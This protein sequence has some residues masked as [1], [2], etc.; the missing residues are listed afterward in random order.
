MESGS[1]EVELYQ[2][3]ENIDSKIFQRLTRQFIPC[4]LCEA[5]PKGG[6]GIVSSAIEQGEKA[7]FC[8]TVTYL[9]DARGPFTG[10]VPARLEFPGRSGINKGILEVGKKR[11]EVRISK[12]KEKREKKRGAL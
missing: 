8:Y 12:E 3:F 9:R 6:E 11:K 5:T 1:S 10:F 2:F 4:I 7:L